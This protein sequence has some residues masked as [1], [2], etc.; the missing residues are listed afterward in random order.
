MCGVSR[1]V[2]GVALRSVAC[3]GLLELPYV[4]ASCVL[5]VSKCVSCVACELGV[6]RVVHGVCCVRAARR[7]L[8]VLCAVSRVCFVRIV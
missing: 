8:Y 2:R 7:V 6:V 1:V 3:S 4:F 5:C